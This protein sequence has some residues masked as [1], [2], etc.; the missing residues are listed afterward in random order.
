MCQKHLQSFC[1][2]TGLLK[3]VSLSLLGF[4]ATFK[5]LLALCWA[6]DDAVD[7][8]L[9]LLLIKSMWEVLFQEVIPPFVPRS[10]QNHPPIPLE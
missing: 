4:I 10:I 7:M 1:Y 6:Q 9:S 5:P 2:T 3:S 8:A